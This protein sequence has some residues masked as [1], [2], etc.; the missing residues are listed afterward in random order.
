VPPA[1][2]GDGVGGWRE[3]GGF[4][5]VVE[6]TGHLVGGGHGGPGGIQHGERRLHD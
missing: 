4:E 2:G 6:R 1:H 3:A 5:D